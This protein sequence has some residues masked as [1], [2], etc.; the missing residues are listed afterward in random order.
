MSLEE[1]TS[2]EPSLKSMNFSEL[3]EYLMGVILSFPKNLPQ[4]WSKEMLS[5]LLCPR[6]YWNDIDS[7]VTQDVL[8]S[9]RN[10][11]ILNLVFLEDIYI[12]FNEF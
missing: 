11:G 7:P 1:N 5:L 6:G 12:S 10:E 4:K 2:P 8:I 3:K 9:L